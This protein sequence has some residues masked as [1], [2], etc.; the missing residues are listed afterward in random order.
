VV[1]QKTVYMKRLCNGKKL[2]IT[3]PDDWHVHLRDGDLLNAVAP[4][5]ERY[6]GR[7]LVMPNLYPPILTIKEALAYQE[8]IRLAAPKLQTVMTLYWHPGLLPEEIRK[9]KS[10]HIVRSNGT[11]ETQRPTL[12]GESLTGETMRTF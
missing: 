6:F 1:T 2:R 7:V 9:A 11:L 5:S 4:F 12:I 3:L 10:H 8:R